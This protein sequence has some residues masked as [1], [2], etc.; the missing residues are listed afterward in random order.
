[1]LSVLESKYVAPERPY[2]Q[3]ELR[4][5]RERLHKR[6]RLGNHMV[7]HV[8]C[9]HFYLTKQNGRKEREIIESGNNDVGNC[10]VCWKLSK[11][12]DPLFDR[13]SDLVN[14][15]VK[16]FKTES[17]FATY[18]DLDLETVYYKWLYERH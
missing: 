4:E 14:S 13:A 11:T 8:E 10:S 7:R 6:L 1:M 2:S 18:D 9:G 5:T 15:Y 3:N 12:Q 17:K 16:T